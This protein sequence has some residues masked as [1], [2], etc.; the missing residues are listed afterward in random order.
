MSQTLVFLKY[1]AS[2]R[3][4]Q[5]AA[6]AMFQCCRFVCLAVWISFQMTTISQY[7]SSG[8]SVM[9]MGG[10]AIS[11]SRHL[12]NCAAPKRWNETDMFEV[13]RCHVREY[14]IYVC[15][16][17]IIIHLWLRHFRGALNLPQPMC[18]FLHMCL[19]VAFI[20]TTSTNPMWE[21]LENCGLQNHLLTTKCFRVIDHAL[22]SVRPQHF[23]N[24]RKKFVQNS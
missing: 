8:I 5:V 7:L 16:W 6:A 23:P 10:G 3:G 22:C 15:G 12:P 14:I 11:V 18:K 24:F 19:H 9:R 4:L 17:Q 13:S 20:V 2:I 21:A 1:A